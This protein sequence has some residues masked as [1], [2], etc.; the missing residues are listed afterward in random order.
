M[1]R[2]V[3]R[4]GYRLSPGTLYPMLQAMEARGYLTSREDS[5]GRLGR[6]RK[7]YKATRRGKRALVVARERLRELIGDV[8]RSDA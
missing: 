4:H 3:A 5:E 7:L 1:R 6:R 2:K 8:G